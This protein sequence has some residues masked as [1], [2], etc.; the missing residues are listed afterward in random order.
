MAMLQQRA[1]VLF[2]RAWEPDA[3]EVPSHQQ[4]HQVNG[5]PAIVLLLAHHHGADLGRIPN[6]QLMSELSQHLP[7]PQRVAGAL[8]PDWGRSG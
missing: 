1:R 5:I 7:K 4:G 6:H 3:L 8:D 2:F